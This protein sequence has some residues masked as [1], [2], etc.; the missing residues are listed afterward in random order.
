MHLIL[1]KLQ[2]NETED[3]SFQAGTS[4]ELRDKSKLRQSLCPSGKKKCLKSEIQSDPILHEYFSFIVFRYWRNICQYW[5]SI[6]YN[7]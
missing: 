5:G 1:H 7:I 2:A 6:A 3:I 4:Y